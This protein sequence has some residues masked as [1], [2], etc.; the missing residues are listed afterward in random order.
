M[1]N[2]CVYNVTG[3]EHDLSLRASIEPW[4]LNRLQRT[5]P[6]PAVRIAGAEERGRVSYFPVRIRSGSV[7]RSDILR[8]SLRTLDIATM[9]KVCEFN[10]LRTQDKS[11][12]VSQ[13][14][15]WIC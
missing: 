1:L 13:L 12:C 6:I 3:E 2:I 10:L 11:Y 5:A 4:L 8:D 14:H 9:Q 7:G 15:I